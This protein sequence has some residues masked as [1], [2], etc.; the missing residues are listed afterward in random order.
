MI[1][2]AL[3]KRDMATGVKPFIIIFAVLCLY[4]TVIIYMFNPELASMLSD[5]QK[6]LPEMMAAVGMTG[7]AANLLEWIKIYL[8]GF[9]MILF[10]LIFIIILVN[11][12]VASYIDNGSMAS[13]LAT[14]NSRGKIIRTQLLAL[15]IWITLLIICITG[16]GI[17]TCEI[18]FPGDLD[19][20]KYILLNGASLLLQLAV[21]SIAFFAACL[22]TEA[23]H[24]YMIGAGLPILFFLFQMLANMGEKTEWMKYCT[25][26]TLFPAEQIVAGDS[27][28]ALYCIA[29]AGIVVVLAVISHIHFCRRDICV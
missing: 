24:Y 26:Y 2:F 14:P 4:T 10:P 19:I 13:L 29:L 23:K 6:A 21:G 16:V 17:A 11:K 20:T 18:L 15:I 12:L 27:E 25:L 1:S 22:C 7:V 8:Y 28:A 9:L 5:Y 3:L